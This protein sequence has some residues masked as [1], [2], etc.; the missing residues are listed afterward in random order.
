MYL[1]DLDQNVRFLGYNSLHFVKP[2]KLQL[3]ANFRFTCR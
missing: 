1:K 3:Y 2:V